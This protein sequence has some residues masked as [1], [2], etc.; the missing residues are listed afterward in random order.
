MKRIFGSL[1]LLLTIGL[2]A[3]PKADS[4]QE[5]EVQNFTAEVVY[6]EGEVFIDDRLA[7]IGDI[8]EAQ[9]IIRTASNSYCEVIFLEQNIIR[10]MGDSLLHLD[11]NFHQSALE[12]ERGSLAALM[13]KLRSLSHEEPM[14]I[15]TPSV[16][17]GI[18][19]TAFFVKVES[20]QSSYFCACNGQIETRDT[21]GENSLSLDA[22]R[23]MAVRYYQDAQGLHQ[24]PAGLLYHDDEDLNSLAD[25]LNYQIPWGQY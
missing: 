10:V 14:L 1:C 13:N 16:T 19:G 2:G 12:L 8:V 23:H 25:T 24:E 11:L 7:Q 20:P 18:R 22:D 15:T 6:L 17:A 9:S 4:P 3:T 5:G 21:Q